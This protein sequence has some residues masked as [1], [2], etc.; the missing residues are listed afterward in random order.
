VITAQD[1]EAAAGRTA[2]RTR[3]TPVLTLEPAAFGTA[4]PLVLKLELFQ[5]T[6]SFKVRGAFNRILAVTGGEPPGGVIAASGGNHGM[7][8][9]Y[10]ARELG[11]PAE[12]FVPE[13]I[14]PVKVNRLRTFG[15]RVNVT[16]A[17]YADAYEAS[18]RRAAETGALAVH[19]YDQPGVAAGQGTVGRELL[20]QVP[21]VDTVLVAVGGG[22]LLAG[23]ATAVAG[24]AKVVAVEPEQAPTLHAALAAGRPVDVE[25]GGLAADALG[26][27]RVGDIGYQVALA[28]G[29]HSVLVP[30]EAI[31]T[32]RSRLWAAAR[33]AAEYGGA[34]TLAAL[35]CGAYKPSPG[36]RVAAVI[37]GGNTNPS[38]LT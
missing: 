1:I 4:Q 16:G 13:S 30:E 37:C 6:G 27:R 2:G 19:A 28:A 9:A 8:V 23:V 34:A 29:V 20:D 25:V 17:F 7:A 3:L 14:S 24:R 21:A 26:A 11:L 10:V 38:D 33:V 12:I 35:L 36:E 22:G 32:A 5:H 15:A 18:R 31:V